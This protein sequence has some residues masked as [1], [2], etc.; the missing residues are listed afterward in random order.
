M[1]HSSTRRTFVYTV[2]GR[3]TLTSSCEFP[4]TK[5]QKKTRKRKIYGN[6]FTL[7][8]ITEKMKLLHETCISSHQDQQLK[9]CSVGNISRNL[10]L[11]NKKRRLFFL[12]LPPPAFRT[13]LIHEISIC[14]K[15]LHYHKFTPSGL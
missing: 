11:K 10:C 14:C 8:H 9:A 7:T 15:I 5:Q 2:V 4:P 12:F 6:L 3:L 1:E 13:H